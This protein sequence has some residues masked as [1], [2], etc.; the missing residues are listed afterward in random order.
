MR[1][2]DCLLCDADAADGGVTPNPWWLNLQAR[3]D[4]TVELK[5][6]SRAV[7]AREAVGDERDRLWAMF[8]GRLGDDVGAIARLRSGETAVVVFEPRNA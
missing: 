2:S 4:V 6:A 5:G 3:S 1:E 7:S 8:K